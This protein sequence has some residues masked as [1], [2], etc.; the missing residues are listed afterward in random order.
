MECELKMEFTAGETKK[1]HDLPLMKALLTEPPH[2][3]H[4]VSTYFDTDNLD[5][6]RQGVSLRVRR[7]GNHYVQ[8][9]KTTEPVCAGA[10]RTRRNRIDDQRPPAGSRRIAGAEPHR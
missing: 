1:L 4:L 6:F 7:A 3:D 2:T 9:L 8:T 10:F 5:L